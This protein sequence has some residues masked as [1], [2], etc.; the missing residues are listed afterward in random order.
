MGQ[1]TTRGLTMVSFDP[2][3]RT[4]TAGFPLTSALININPNALLYSNGTSTGSCGCG[5]AARPRATVRTRTT[6]HRLAEFTSADSSLLPVTELHAHSLL[7][8]F[9]FA[10]N[11][12]RRSALYR[13]KLF[14]PLELRG[15][16]VLL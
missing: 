5:N 4:I 6:E 11:A 1:N 2:V 15:E 8:R 3:S 13:G 9:Q 16:V 10:V 14:I 7:S 12:P